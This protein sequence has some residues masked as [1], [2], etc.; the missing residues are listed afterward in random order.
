MDN[1]KLV[2]KALI[3]IADN[4]KNQPS[5]SEIAKHCGY[6]EFHFQKIFTVWAGISPKR[7]LS[8]TNVNYAKKILDNGESIETTTNKIGLSSSSRLHDLFV[9]I[10]AMTP[11]EYKNDGKNL[12]INYSFLSTNF[13]D[14]L[15]ASTNKGIVEIIFA[16]KDESLKELKLKWSNAR[17]IEK[18]L[19]SHKIVR[20]FINNNLNSESKINLHLKGT[21]FQIK[22]WEALLKISSGELK[23]YADVSKSTGTKGYRAVGT[24][25]GSNHIAFII[26]CHRV[27]KSTGEFGNYRWG[28]EK[29]LA[30]LARE[31]NSTLSV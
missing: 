28:K 3:Y 26:P 20:S 7:F 25:I 16:P 2:E 13:G 1:Y 29:K 21:N 12:V 30:M 4:F 27:I 17:L 10:V 6:S 9:N 15:V 8:V 19:E 11:N 23:T 31:L 14:A 18:D 24:A 5:L 22:V